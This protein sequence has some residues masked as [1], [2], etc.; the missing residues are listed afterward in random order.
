MFSVII[1]RYNDLNVFIPIT[2]LHEVDDA[3]NPL[4]STSPRD[5]TIT[6][7]IVNQLNR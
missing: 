3:T 5:S 1:R 7:I 6:Y 2:T 4:I